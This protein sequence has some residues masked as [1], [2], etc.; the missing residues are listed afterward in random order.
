[1]RNGLMAHGFAVRTLVILFAACLL[2][3]LSCD[4][5]L[6]QQDESVS[7]EQ[8]AATLA[9]QFAR[10]RNNAQ[11]GGSYVIEVRGNAS[12]S[13]AQAALPA[14]RTGVTITL[15]GVGGMREIRLSDNGVLFIVG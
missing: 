3:L 4:A 8:A 2:S 10:L 14:G 9:D 13:P 7:E 12:I 6:S 15:R 11:S 1:M 5:P